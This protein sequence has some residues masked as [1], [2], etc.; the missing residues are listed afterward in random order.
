M[1]VCVSGMGSGNVCLQWPGDRLCFSPQGWTP[2]VQGGPK[3]GLESMYSLNRE[4]RNKNYWTK[5]VLKVFLVGVDHISFAHNL[6]VEFCS[7]EAPTQSN[8]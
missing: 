3:Q 5:F 7:H 8:I 1:C 6:E 4:T 2:R